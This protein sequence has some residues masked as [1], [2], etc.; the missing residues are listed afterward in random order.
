MAT[1]FG[2]N[3]RSEEGGTSCFMVKSNIYL[4]QQSKLGLIKILVKVMDK[5]N[6]G[7]DYLWQKFP[8]ISE[9]TMKEGIFIGPPINKLIED[10]DF[11]IK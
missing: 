6:E 2:S 5:E 11:S 7:F 1:E 4:P 3:T 9:A 10:H 8:K